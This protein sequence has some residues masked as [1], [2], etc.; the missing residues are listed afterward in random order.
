VSIDDLVQQG[1]EI[2]V[3]VAK[4]SIGKKGAR[5]TSHVALPGRLMVFTPTAGHVGVSRKIVDPKE[6]ARLKKAVLKLKRHESHGFIVRTAGEGRSEKELAADIRY[7]TGLWDEIRQKVEKVS[8]PALVYSEPGIVE[9]VVRDRLSDDFKSIRVD[10]EAEYRRVK[11]FVK[12]FEPDLL[13][14]VRLYKGRK[15]IFDEFGV[16][17]EI[18]KALKHKVWLKNGGYIVINQT[19]ALVAIDVNTGRFVGRTNSL[20]ETITKTNLD[21]VREVVHQIRLRDLGGI[22]IIDFIDMDES[23]NRQKV[24]E[25]LLRELAKDKSPSKILKFNEFGL[26][27][28]TRKRV[29]QSLEKSLCQPCDCCAGTGMTKSLRTVAYSI[30]HEARRML[31]YFGKGTKILVRCHPEVAKVLKDGEKAVIREIEELTSKSVILKPD[32][33]L[34]LEQY[35]LV[36]K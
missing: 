3:Q 11:G 18:E 6:R 35:D 24:M 1:Q 10:E 15:P 27:A 9:R 19:E 13:K 29:K 17:S 28:V 23:R 14:M 36:E 31:P 33:S 25:A 4:E 8:A 12:T 7:L 20:E 2:V 21:A 32:S 26:V 30:H 5:I 16:N 34:H 22:I